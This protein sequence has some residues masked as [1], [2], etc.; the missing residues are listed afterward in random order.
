[1]SWAD[2]EG[3]NRVATGGG[4]ASYT[5]Q[6]AAKGLWLPSAGNGSGVP[7]GTTAIGDDIDETDASDI[8]TPDSSN[9]TRFS[10]HRRGINAVDYQA[11]TAARS[12]IAYETYANESWQKFWRDCING[13]LSAL[14]VAVGQ[15]RIYTDAAVGGTYYDY[16]VR[17]LRNC[18]MESLVRGWQGKWTIKIAR[19]ER[20]P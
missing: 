18:E 2:R 8:G 1:M 11:C 12:R 10:Y 16:W 9:V 14:L 19:L 17:G 20:V 15:V 13:V 4:T 7:I 5:S 6:G 3:L